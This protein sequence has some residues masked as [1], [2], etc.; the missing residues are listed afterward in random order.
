MHSA[1]NEQTAPS[2]LSYS[3]AW[4]DTLR[5]LRANARLLAALAGVFLFLPGLL[6]DRYKPQPEQAAGMEFTQ[7][8]EQMTLYMQDAWPWLLLMNFLSF[9]GIISIY[10]LLLEETRMTVGSALARAVPIVPFFFLLTMIFNLAVGIGL[11]LLI[12]P[13]IYLLGR[14][15]LASP[16]LAVETP[17][18]PVAALRRSWRMSK[19]RGW[20][21]GLLFVLVFVIASILG[22]AIQAG[23]GSIFLIALGNQGIGGL[24]VAILKAIVSAVTM[25]VLTVLTAAIYRAISARTKVSADIFS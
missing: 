23:I 11:L 10:L 12:A 3:A 6:V 5:M 13:G 2:T 20:T 21:I 18:S 14:L 17:R 16:I 1:M 22:L 24:L 15:V 8:I 25:V 19:G 4:D 9:V 7:F